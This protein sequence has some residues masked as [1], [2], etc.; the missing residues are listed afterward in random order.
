MN[1]ASRAFRPVVV[2]PVYNH[3]EAIGAMTSCRPCRT[4]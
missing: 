2:I 1:L 4:S 3:E